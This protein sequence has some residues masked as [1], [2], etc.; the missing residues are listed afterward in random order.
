M[1]TFF[2]L[3]HGPTAWNA[4]KRIQGRTDTELSPEGRAL[5]GTWAQALADLEVDAVLTSDLVRA[6]E[7]A[8]LVTAGRDLPTHRDPRL[9]EQDWGEWTG[10]VKPELK[11]LGKELTRREKQGF[12]FRPPGGES[13]EEVLCR[14]CDALMDFAAEHPHGRVLVVTHNGVLKALLA[15][16]SGLEFLPNDPPLPQGYRLHRIEC[17]DGELALGGSGPEL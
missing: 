1:T 13:R 15:A 17:L 11:K 7:T 9:A 6:V 3:R 5:A 12:D 8:D 4:E 16:L 14:A 10:L 2:L